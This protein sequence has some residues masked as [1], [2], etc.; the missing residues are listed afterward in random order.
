M[1][2]AGGKGGKVGLESYRIKDIKESAPGVDLSSPFSEISVIDGADDPDALI[3][4][5]IRGGEYPA[6]PPPRSYA[7]GSPGGDEGGSSDAA[8]VHV[9]A[10]TDC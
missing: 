6:P 2:R 10:A 1:G 3:R 4:R 8:L 9:G 5:R 7:P